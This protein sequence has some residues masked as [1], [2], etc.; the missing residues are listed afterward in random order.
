MEHNAATMKLS[1]V[2]H[3]LDSQGHLIEELTAQLE[4]SHLDRAALAIEDIGWRPLMGSSDESPQALNLLQLKN[5]SELCRALDTV[6]PLVER[7][8]EVRSGY[9]WGSGVS[10]VR[11]EFAASR[12]GRRP[13]RSDAV[14]LP[15]GIEHVMTGTLAQQEIERT[16]ATD[17]N[18]FFLVDKVSKEV[19]RIPLEDISDAV[20]QR[21]NRENIQYIQRTWDHQELENPSASDMRVVWYPTSR[22]KGPPLETIDRVPVDATRVIVHVPFNRKVGWRWG[23]PD[24]MPAVSW[25][26][27]YK[28]FLENSATLTK[29]YARFAWKVT[30]ERGRGARRA[31]SQ[32]AAPPRRDPATG[33]PMAIGASA[34]MGAG[35]DLT[36][37]QRN[38]SV[39]FRAG[40]PLAAMIAAG[41]GV[42]LPALTCDPSTGNRA[43][44][45]SVDAPTAKVMESRQRIMN[46][47]FDEI[48]RLL[49]LRIRLR[50]PPIND[51]PVHRKL[52]AIN[53]AASLGVLS[54]AEIRVMVLDAWNDKWSDF[55]TAVPTME[56][57][58][59]TMQ[60]SVG[61]QQ[62]RQIE[63]PSYGDHGLR[64]EGG[65][66]HVEDEN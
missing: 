52:Q 37:L 46:N 11:A 45:E 60:Q 18:L 51:E 62:P 49:G 48:F 24:I 30:S 14:R 2:Q 57:L 15:E 39:D 47:A 50:W 16:A 25:T 5:I 29:A 26:K 36:P 32:L 1:E 56:D 9:I 17:G 58:P 61:T 54:A 65:Q 33:E 28:E 35:Q 42:P 4:E 34:V 66:A 20:S 64:D 31:A 6:N 41:L 63:P 40:Q 10:V 27:A 38:T 12:P 53:M 7:G 19:I 8:V 3:V 22:L 55:S 23:V 44:A 43:T 13:A 59:V 21:G